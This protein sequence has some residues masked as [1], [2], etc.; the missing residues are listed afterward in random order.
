MCCLQ[1]AAVCRIQGWERPAVSAQVTAS[2]HVTL[3]LELHPEARVSAECFTVY[4]VLPLKLS[5]FILM[6]PLRG[7]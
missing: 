7:G 4:H 5:Y 2:S 3:T 6:R 1:L